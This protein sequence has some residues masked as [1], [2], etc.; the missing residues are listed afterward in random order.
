MDQWLIRTQNLID[1]KLAESTQPK[2]I[3][4]YLIAGE[5]IDAIWQLIH[6]EEVYDKE[7][8]P[9]GDDLGDYEY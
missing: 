7:Y 1:R 8:F 5:L 4:K 6:V 3:A 2:N 9:E